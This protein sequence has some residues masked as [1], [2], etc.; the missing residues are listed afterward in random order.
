MK[1]VVDMN[2]G[3]PWVG[4]LEAAGHKA[5][6]WSAI[7]SPEAEDEIIMAWARDNGHVVLTADLGFGARLIRSREDGPSVTQ[8]RMKVTLVNMIGARVV[9]VLANTAADLAAGALVT[10][11]RERYRVRL[12]AETRQS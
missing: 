12:L 10:I 8:L 11:E 7:G 1:I 5:V 4:R 6:H 3:S 9:E 2:L